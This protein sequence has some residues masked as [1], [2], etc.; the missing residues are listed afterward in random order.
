[1]YTTSIVSGLDILFLVDFLPFSAGE[2]TFVTSC[3]PKKYHIR[4]NYCTYMYPISTQS[5]NSVV[6]RLQ[7]V[8]FVHFCI[9]IMV[10]IL[11]SVFDLIT[12]LCAEV[13]QNYWKNL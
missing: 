2:T 12:I 10:G 9:D 5:S 11:N 8:D 13:F 7:P 3:T 6:I 1:M 4:P